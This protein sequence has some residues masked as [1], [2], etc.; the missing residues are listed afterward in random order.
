MREESRCAEDAGHPE[1]PLNENPAMQIMIDLCHD[2]DLAIAGELQ[3]LGHAPSDTEKPLD[4]YCLW[5]EMREREIPQRPYR[6]LRSRELQSSNESQRLAL[7]LSEVEAA[8]QEGLPV[9]PYLSARAAKV[10]KAGRDHMLLHWRI[11]HLHLSPISTKKP[12]GLVARADELLFFR[13]EGDEV[14]FIGILPHADPSAFERKAL[15]EVVERNW[16]HLHHRLRTGYAERELTPAERRALRRGNVMHMEEIDGKLIMPT[17]GVS[18]AGSPADATR[19]FDRQQLQLLDLE[20]MLR[21]QPADVFP[22]IAEL[23]SAH[24]RLKSMWEYGF[25]LVETSTGLERRVQI[26]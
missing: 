21:N 14:H 19:A 9:A 25:D 8:F 3:A 6:V 24:V 10:G 26:L 5:F 11:R 2:L 23:E 18:S 17:F 12:N 20:R 13:I 4:R 22:E 16:P 1:L 7:V 15:L